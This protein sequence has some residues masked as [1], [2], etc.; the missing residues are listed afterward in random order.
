MIRVALTRVSLA[1]ILLAGTALPALAKDAL[2]ITGRWQR[3]GIGANA[4]N[5][6]EGEKKFTPPPRP[7]PPLKP[8]YLE[9]WKAFEKE[10]KEAAAAGTPF[11]TTWNDCIGSGMPEMMAAAFPME[12]LQTDGQ[13]TII[14]EAFMEIRRIYLDQPQVSLDDIE[15]GYYGHSV[16]HWEDGELH[17]ETIGIKPDVQVNDAPH[18]E[19]MKIE[20]TFH[21]VSDDIMWVDITLVD[22]DYL[23]KPWSWSYAFQKMPDYQMQEY[24]CEGNREYTDEDGYQRI[25]LPE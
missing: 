19:T 10:K 7:E 3:Y 21:M 16:G 4:A 6:A 8:E 20:E 1:T 12:I 24:V 13:I 25:R 9:K 15:L 17:A 22:P 2:D 14:Q 18:S 11:A 5:M 23:T